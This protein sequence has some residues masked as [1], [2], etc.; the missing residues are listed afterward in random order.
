MTITHH[1]WIVRGLCFKAGLYWQGLTHDLSK[2]S[3]AEFRI[4]ARYCT[5]KRSPNAV[6]REKFGYSEAWMHHKGRNK[7]HYEY[8]S[9]LSLSTHQ[10]EPVAMPAR[11][12][13]EMVMDRVAACKVYQGEDYTDRAAL[14]YLNRAHETMLMHP[15]TQYK[16]RYILE[17][18]AEEGEPAMM[19]LIREYLLKNKPFPEK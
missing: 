15:D 14:D 8:W 1:R 9:D 12:I 3:P 2:Y 18:L 10:Y 5:G 13:A 19:A 7:H 16:L 4:G 17:L 11:Y 6:E